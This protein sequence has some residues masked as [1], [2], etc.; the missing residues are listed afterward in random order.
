MQTAIPEYKIFNDSD[1]CKYWIEN[2]LLDE[3]DELEE[4]QSPAE[5][6]LADLPGIAYV[7]DD[8]DINEDIIFMI[9]FDLN[10][11]T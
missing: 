7:H 4:M 6:I 10:K 1:K 11:D 5:E 8:P 3:E 2:E 9:S